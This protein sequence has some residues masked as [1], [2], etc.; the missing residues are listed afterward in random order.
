LLDDLERFVSIAAPNSVVQ[1]TPT[2]LAAARTSTP[3]SSN[4]LTA[5]KSVVARR[6]EQRLVERSGSGALFLFL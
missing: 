3:C 6:V 2:D 4:D 1:R 5:A